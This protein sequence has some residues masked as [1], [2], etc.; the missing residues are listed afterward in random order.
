MTALIEK[1][2]ELQERSMPVAGIWSESWKLPWT[3]CVARPRMQMSAS[4][5]RGAPQGRAVSAT[6]T[7]A[8]PAVT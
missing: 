3:R 5:R 7:S 8:R 1:Q 2:G 4:C 6:A